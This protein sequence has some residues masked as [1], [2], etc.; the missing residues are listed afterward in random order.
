MS[1]NYLNNTRSTSKQN[2]ISNILNKSTILH[3]R[4]PFSFFLMPVFLFAVSQAPTINL[5]PLVISFIIF[6]FLV[7]PSSNGYNSFHDKDTGSIGGLKNPPQTTSNLLITTHI[8]DLTAI[9]GSLIISIWFAILVAGFI[10][11]SRAYSNRNIR[12][13][14]LPIT[15]FLIVA[16]FQGGYIYLATLHAVTGT[17][18][19]SL[20]FSTPHIR[21]M[22]ISSLFVGSI[23]PLTQIYQHLS[24][25]Q[26]GV[27]TLSF[28]L[29]YLGSFMFSSILFGI[30]FFMLY[31]HFKSTGNDSFT[32]LFLIIMLPVITYMSYWGYKV[33]RNHKYANYEYTM[34]MNTITSV[35][36]NVFFLILIFS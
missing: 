15:A 11:M 30:A 9:A 12:L 13:K 17:T 34:V 14:K 6:H 2:T 4:F 33:F 32:F 26:D 1:A 20:L 36:M 3:L 19:L 27:I 8:M 31:Y 7:F 24:D 16:I 22:L 29:G 5:I 21:S 10:L 23:Y 25:K 28:K 18:D 35:C